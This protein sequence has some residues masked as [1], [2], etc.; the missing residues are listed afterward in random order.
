MTAAAYE[1]ARQCRQ[2]QQAHMLR[3][4][5][6][7]GVYRAHAVMRSELPLTSPHTLLLPLF[8]AAKVCM[9]PA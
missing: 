3:V 2:Q 8:A 4:C 9:C 1:R 7:V 5:V 6:C